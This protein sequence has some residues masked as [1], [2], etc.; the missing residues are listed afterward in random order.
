MAIMT[1]V[2]TGPLQVTCTHVE[3]G[4]AI[5]TEAPPKEG[6]EKGFSPTDLCAASLGMCAMTLMALMGERHNI[7]LAGLRVEIDK[8]MK[9]DPSAIGS[10]TL[11]FHMPPGEYSDK[12][13]ARLER[14]VK[15]C[16]IH[17]TFAPEV[18]QIID[19]RWP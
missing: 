3:S 19:I 11:V 17:N 5:T 2:Y 10:I 13:K 4:A 16:P 14:A 6:P 12:D 1:A 7:N 15:I 18:E 8:T 9:S